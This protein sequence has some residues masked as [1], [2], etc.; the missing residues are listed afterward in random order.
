MEKQNSA[1]Y[2]GRGLA[3]SRKGDYDTAIADCNE[4][5][6]LDPEDAVAYEARG[7]AH[8]RKKEPDAALADYTKAIQLDP[9][10]TRA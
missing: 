5:I 7:L 1:A 3:L 4:A 6:R 9:K 10:F 8:D 2:R